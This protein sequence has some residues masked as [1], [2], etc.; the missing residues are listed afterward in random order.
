MFPNRTLHPNG[1]VKPV[2]LNSVSE[3]SP[4]PDSLP[5]YSPANLISMTFLRETNDD[6]VVCAKIVRQILDREA[7]DH[8]Q[9][10]FLLKL[11]D[12]ELEEIIGYNE[13]CSI[14]EDQHEAEKNGEIPLFSF[15]KILEHQGLLRPT[16]PD[17]KGS[18]YNVKVLWEDNSTSWEPLNIVGKDDPVTVAKYA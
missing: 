9:I 11:G 2:N 1:D 8:Q 12:G 10:K 4:E 5:K 15:R 13:L 17:Y 6:Q 3:L 14:I 7:E 18:S 16:D